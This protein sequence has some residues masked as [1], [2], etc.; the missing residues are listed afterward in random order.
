MAKFYRLVQEKWAAYARNGEGARIYG[1]RWNPVGMPAVYL[2]GSRALAALEVVVH[3]PRQALRMEWRIF[4]VDVPDKWIESATHLPADWQAQ[5]D[6]LRAQEFGGEW[7]RRRSALA[8]QLPS[9]IIPEEP[10]ILMNP[11]HADA[12]LVKWS[13]PQAFAFDPRL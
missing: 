9:V 2:A 6:S 13:K 5:P 1:G 12:E 8:L 3:A 7:L 4:E 11:E 10:I